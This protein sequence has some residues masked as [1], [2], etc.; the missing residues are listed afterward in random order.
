[1]DEHTAHTQN[2]TYPTTSRS[3]P[4]GAHAKAWKPSL[5]GV[6]SRS[7]S[8]RRDTNCVGQDEKTINERWTVIQLVSI[9]EQKKQPLLDGVQLAAQIG[10]QYKRKWT[11]IYTEKLNISTPDR[12]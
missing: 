2:R 10:E 6:L 3:N 12:K 5:G 1:M 9:Q 8:K 7:A 4:T 11:E